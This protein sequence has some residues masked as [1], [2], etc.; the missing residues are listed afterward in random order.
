MAVHIGRLGLDVEFAPREELRTEIWAKFTHRA[1]RR[2]SRRRGTGAARGVHRSQGALRADAQRAP[3]G[4]TARSRVP[5]PGGLATVSLPSSAPT[6]SASPRRPE[7]VPGFGAA[8]AVVAHLD[9]DGVLGHSHRHGGGGR[10]RVLG[11]VGERL[12]DHEVGGGLDRRG[13]PTVRGRGPPRRGRSRARRGPGPPRARPRSVR[14]AGWMPCASSRSSAEAWASASPTSSRKAT[15]ECGSRSARA[16]ARRTSSASATRCCWAPSCRSRSMRR[17]AASAA[18]MMRACEARSS[19]S[20]RALDLVA[21]QRLLVGAALGDVE[22]RP[23][24]PLLAAGTLDAMAAIEDPAQLSVGALD[25]VLEVERLPV[26]DGVLRLLEHRVAVLGADDAHDRAPRVG[27]EEVARGVA[28]DALDLVADELQRVVVV[29]RGAVDGPG[30]V[31]H[32]RA[33]H[34]LAGVAVGQGSLAATGHRSTLAH[35]PAVRQ[36]PRCRVAP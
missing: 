20:A 3:R 24:H 26:V 22:D 5:S 7:P 18:S 30:H 28:R 23:V 35:R 31:G 10:L 1:P 8:D 2:G 36:G 15:A 32:E 13:E 19:S 34:R 21:A 29:P 9:H 17:R 11:D 4:M 12:G 33:Q 6:R 14:T 16:R 27:T 25:A